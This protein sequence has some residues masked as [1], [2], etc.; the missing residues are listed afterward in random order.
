MARGMTLVPQPQLDS[1]VYAEMKM[2]DPDMELALGVS[3]FFDTQT[4]DRKML[5]AEI[6]ATQ[7]QGSTRPASD[8]DKARDFAS[9]I[10]TCLTLL[11]MKFGDIGWEYK[12]KEGGNEWGVMDAEKLRGKHPGSDDMEDIGIQYEIK[13]SADSEQHKNK[14]QDVTQKIAWF[15]KCILP[16]ANLPDP[17]DPT[18]KMV[19]L[20]AALKIVSEPMDIPNTEDIMAPTLSEQEKAAKNTPA[21]QVTAIV[22]QNP[23]LAPLIMQFVQKIAQQAQAGQ[24]GKPGG[25]GGQQPQPQQQMT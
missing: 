10:A 6:T 19:D 16:F 23:Q 24:H 13:V 2:T 15:E 9:D 12:S 4:P 20:K 7:Q 11:F 8:V 5:K 17:D 1:T 22:Q 14:Q 18:K 25:N 3:K 21:N